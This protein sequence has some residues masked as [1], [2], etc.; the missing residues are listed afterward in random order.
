MY[1]QVCVFSRVPVATCFDLLF[2][3]TP[4]DS[5]IRNEDILNDLEKILYSISVGAIGSV[6]D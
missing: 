2:T 4:T 5:E 3:L 1:T 6:V